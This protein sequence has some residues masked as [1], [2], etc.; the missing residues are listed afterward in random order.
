MWKCC[1]ANAAKCRAGEEKSQSD[2]TIFKIPETRIP[3]SSF[4]IR[5]LGRYFEDSYRHYKNLA[6]YDRAQRQAQW[7]QQQ[8]LQE[9]EAHVHEAI[10]LENGPE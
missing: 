10:W 9:E 4:R 3:D 2:G 5:R 6:A 8:Q 1:V 7:N